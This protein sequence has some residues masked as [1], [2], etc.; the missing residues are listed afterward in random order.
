MMKEIVHN[1]Y[2]GSQDDYEQIVKYEDGWFVVHACKEP[3]HREAL[4]YSGKGA[5]KES[6]EYFFAYRANRLILNL[7]DAPNPQYIPKQIIDEAIDFIDKHISESKIF[8]HCNQGLSRS[9][10]IGLL[11]LHHIGIISVNDFCEAEKEYLNYYPLYQP[12]DG[13]RM[14]AAENWDKYGSL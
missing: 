11:Y 1:L 13:M 5:P 10:V 8:V 12:G 6:P 4:G 14:F 7:V 2:I 9:A 3:Y